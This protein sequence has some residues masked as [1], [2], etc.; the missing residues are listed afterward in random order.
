MVA[1]E[2]A[3]TEQCDGVVQLPLVQLKVNKHLPVLALQTITRALL[4]C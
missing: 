4:Y 1:L 2:Q 3:L